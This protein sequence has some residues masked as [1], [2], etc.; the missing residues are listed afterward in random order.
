MTA[1]TVTDGDTGDC[2]Y[3]KQSEVAYM[4]RTSY[5]PSSSNREDI[6]SMPFP[7][8]SWME[9]RGKE[10]LFSKPSNAQD[11]VRSANMV[12]GSIPLKLIPPTGHEDVHPLIS[13]LNRR[14]NTNK[15]TGFGEGGQLVSS[16]TSGF[17]FDVD[18]LIIP[19][20]DLILKERIGAG[21]I[22][23]F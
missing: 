4:E 18:D 21:I 2:M 14:V 9:V 1:R 13:L 23:L 22:F 19:W 3:P 16:K 15:G 12:R 10:Q 11:V 7:T 17:S 6:S 5:P 8:N 20:S